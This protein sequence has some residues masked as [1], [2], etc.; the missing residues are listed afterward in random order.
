MTELFGGRPRRFLRQSIYGPDGQRMTMALSEEALKEDI[1]VA[2]NALRERS[3]DQDVEI[4]W[5]D[6]DDRSA[7]E[8]AERRS[9][10]RIPADVRVRA[11]LHD[12]LVA[13]FHLVKPGGVIANRSPAPMGT[14]V[15]KATIEAA[16]RHPSYRNQRVVFLT[17]DM[18]IVELD[19]G[20]TVVAA[21]PPVRAEGR[22]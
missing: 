15:C 5:H 22:P 17:G 20:V 6:G 13:M 9:R 16:A 14:A 1:H 3:G 19:R 10:A 12:W 18:E 4:F 7:G 8:E 2:A 21:P 11:T